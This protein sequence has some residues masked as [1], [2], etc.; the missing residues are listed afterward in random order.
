V[1]IWTVTN[2]LVSR[3]QQLADTYIFRAA[4]GK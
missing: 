4:V 3:Y 2:G 1:H